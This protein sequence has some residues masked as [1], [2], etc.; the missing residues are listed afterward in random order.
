MQHLHS[1]VHGGKNDLAREEKEKKRSPCMILRVLK[2]ENMQDLRNTRD[3]LLAAAA[4]EMRIE[5]FCRLNEGFYSGWIE[6][7]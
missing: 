4:N 5:F 2:S 7:L 6:H 3:R 1:G